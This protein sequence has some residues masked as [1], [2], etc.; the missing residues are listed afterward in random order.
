MN[1]I[2][3][4][5]NG[6]ALDSPTPATNVRGRILAILFAYSF[7][8]WFNR[9]SIGAAGNAY[10]MDDYDIS[11]TAMG[12]LDSALLIPYA[13]LM[14][15]GGWL[16]DRIGPWKALILMGFGSAVF[17]ALTG[18]VGWFVLSGTALWL[19]LFAVRALMG[20]FTA[21]IY[22]ASSRI[23]ASWFPLS[24][25][26]WI[27]GLVIGAALL[28]I[29]A[30]FFGFGVLMDLLGWQ[31]A[32]I[33]SGGVT[34]ILALGWTIHGRDRPDQHRSVNPAEIRLIRTGE[35]K[36]YLGTDPHRTRPASWRPLL[37]NRSLVLLTVSYA[38]IGYFEYMFYFWIEHYFGKVLHM[39]KYDSRLAATIANLG[40]GVGMFAGGW[41][42][43]W[44]AIRLGQ[45][46]ARV[47]VPMTGLVA[48]AVFLGLG[49]LAQNPVTIVIWISLANGFSGDLRGTH[50]GDS[51]LPGWPARS[52]RGRD[53]Q[54][55]R[56]RGRVLGANRHSLD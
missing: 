10:L 16:T 3:A 28:G 23:V 44:C 47:I 50:V 6:P 42:T 48:G 30:V 39:S 40:M 12:M 45:R 52:H 54:H 8:S 46:R 36:L 25:R 2:P 19:S 9:V 32:F 5:S 53:L 21:P 55:R 43:D 27:N 49:L 4:P 14:T 18:A 31:A 17:G 41:L 33:I 15:P 56:Q 34:A 29:A 51:D 35:T 13:I 11:E 37:R 24:N 20:V 22:P 38:A 1:G 7:M 26:A